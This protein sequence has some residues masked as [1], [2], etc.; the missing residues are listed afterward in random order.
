MG[1]FRKKNKA[2]KPP[3]AQRLEQAR[4]AQRSDPD[5]EGPPSEGD[6]PEDEDSP[7]YAGRAPTVPNSWDEG[8]YSG[9]ILEGLKIGKWEAKRYLT[10]NLFPPK[11][12]HWDQCGEIA[13]NSIRQYDNTLP[14][15]APPVDW[16]D[17]SL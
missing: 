9:Q 1:D 12:I 5:S 17:L 4:R 11:D 16:G 6:E 8:Y 2:V 15:E 10:I 14:S 13:K 7:D 3:T